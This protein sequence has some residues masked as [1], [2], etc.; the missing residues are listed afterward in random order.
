LYCGYLVGDGEKTGISQDIQVCRVGYLCRNALPSTARSRNMP[1]SM[2]SPNENIILSVCL[3]DFKFR[4]YR[5]RFEGLRV[6]P[7]H[8]PE[9]QNRGVGVKT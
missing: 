1:G 6:S 4:I 2:A 7:S 3:G 8:S 5:I 9:R